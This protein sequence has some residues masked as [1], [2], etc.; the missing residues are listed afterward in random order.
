MIEVSKE[1][2]VGAL[3]CLSDYEFQKKSW[4]TEMEDLLY[5][6]SGCCS[7]DENVEEIF[8]FRNI[9]EAFDAGE[10]VFD[11]ETDQALRDLEKVCD[12]LGYNWSGKEKELLESEGMAIVR[13]MAKKCLKMIA[14]SDGSQSTVRYVTVGES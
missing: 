14:A 12:A 5:V 13:E 2:I 3:K 8:L 1:Y 10:I 11:K 6:E 7:F 4:F 9:K